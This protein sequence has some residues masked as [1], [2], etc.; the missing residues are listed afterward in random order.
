MALEGSS[1]P[2]QQRHSHHGV[3]G[4]TLT[5]QERLSLLLVSVL[6]II[7]CLVLVHL[8]QMLYKHFLGFS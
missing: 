8:G 6:S 7:T 4:R 1:P 2:A 5:H 3:V